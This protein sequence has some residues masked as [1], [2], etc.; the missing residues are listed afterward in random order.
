LVE[1]IVIGS[2]L[3]GQDIIAG[4]RKRYRLANALIEL[5]PAVTSAH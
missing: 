4:I 5:R 1:P 3:H 2:L